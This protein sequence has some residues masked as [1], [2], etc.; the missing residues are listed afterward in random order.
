MDKQDFI[1]KATEYYYECADVYFGIDQ[2]CS[3][4]GINIENSRGTYDFL[5]D[6]RSVLMASNLYETEEISPPPKPLKLK[7][8][9]RARIF[10]L[11]G[12]VDLYFKELETGRKKALELQKKNEMKL[13][14][15]L[16]NAKNIYKTYWWTFIFA[17][18]GLS[19]SLILL[20]LKLMGK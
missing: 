12:S 15:D 5:D 10:E 18:L 8:E 6:L 19:I 13:D 1:R 11:D 7:H 17:L 2:V 9:V 3:S 16:K 20:V 4:I 14:Y